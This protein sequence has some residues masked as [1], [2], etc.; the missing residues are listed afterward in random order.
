MKDDSVKPSHVLSGQVYGWC[1]SK[2]SNC[3]GWGFLYWKIFEKFHTIKCNAK[4][5]VRMYFAG[6]CSMCRGRHWDRRS[7]YGE[8]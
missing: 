4:A 6:F 5:K 2:A 8:K 3:E 1:V 7:R